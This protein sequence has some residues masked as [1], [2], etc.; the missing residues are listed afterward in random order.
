LNERFRWT[1]VPP[2]PRALFGGPL[3]YVTETWR[4]RSALL[5]QRFRHVVLLAR[6]PRVRDGE[7][8]EDYAVYRVEGPKGDVLAEAAPAQA[9]TADKTAR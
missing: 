6:I 5:A 3:L 7:P 9:I 4:D 1:N 2:P 8:I